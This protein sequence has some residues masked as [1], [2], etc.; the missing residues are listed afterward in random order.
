MRAT[1]F[2]L[3]ALLCSFGHAHES[4]CAKKARLAKLKLIPDPN[5]TAPEV[6]ANGQPKMVDNPED[7][8]P[9]ALD[10]EDDGPW[11][12]STMPNPLFSWDPPLIPNPD[13]NPAVVHR[14]VPDRDP[15]GAPVGHS[16]HH[17]HRSARGG[18]A[19]YA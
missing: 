10:D 5:A 1:L 7:I 8:K 12:R 17:R 2:L 15:Q 4:C 9:D 3:A 16:R 6:D 13:Y 19:A 11:E 14:R 18:A